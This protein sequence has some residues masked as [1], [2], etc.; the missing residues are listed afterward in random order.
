MYRVYELRS[1]RLMRFS[2]FQ[3]G[4]GASLKM[5]LRG[6]LE[7]FFSFSWLWSVSQPIRCDKDQF[8]TPEQAPYLP[9]D[10]VFVSGTK[11]FPETRIF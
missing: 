2:D 6:A 3:V 10:L 4:T 11:K 7:L 9:L 1:R 5:Q 8:I